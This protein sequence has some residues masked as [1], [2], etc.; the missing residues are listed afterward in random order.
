VLDI[1]RAT[2]YSSAVMARL[3]GHVVAL[4]ENT[5]QTMLAGVPN[6]TVVTGPLN[7]GWGNDAPYDVIMIEGAAEVVPQALFS[8]LKEGG[9]LLAVVG[10]APMGK[11]TIY[12]LSNGHVTAQSLFDAAAPALSGFARP[13]AFVF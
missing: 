10:A 1:G 2:G 12:Q 6:V 7:A 3:A 11:A 5:G 8:Q 9:R 13:P 4:D